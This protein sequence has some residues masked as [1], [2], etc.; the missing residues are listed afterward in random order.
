MPTSQGKPGISRY[1]ELVDGPGV[2]DTLTVHVDGE[3]H[4]IYLPCSMRK[5]AEDF[6]LA[7]AKMSEAILILRG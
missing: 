5:R 4:S 2:W 3:E 7:V 1:I 6:A